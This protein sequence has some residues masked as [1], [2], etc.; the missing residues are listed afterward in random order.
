M[1]QRQRVQ[2][3][4]LTTGVVSCYSGFIKL[5]IP[6]VPEKICVLQSLYTEASFRTNISISNKDH[7]L[8]TCIDV[9]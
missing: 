2:E 7:L 4:C 3:P 1:I 9:L 8:Q 6:M 5:Q